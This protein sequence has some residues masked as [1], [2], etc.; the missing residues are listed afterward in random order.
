MAVEGCDE[1]VERVLSRYGRSS[2][3]GLLAYA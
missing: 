3:A 2:G 1:S